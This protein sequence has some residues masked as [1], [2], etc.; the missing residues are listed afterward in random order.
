[1]PLNKETKPI[2]S[3]KFIEYKRLWLLVFDFLKIIF[4]YLIVVVDIIILS[5]L[6]K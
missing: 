6:F 2:N 4:L 3:L 1:M 5:Y